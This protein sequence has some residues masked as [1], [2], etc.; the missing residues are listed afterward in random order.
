V[1]A[2]LVHAHGL[3]PNAHG[4][5]PKTATTAGVVVSTAIGIIFIIIL[6]RAFVIR[7]I[8]LPFVVFT[9]IFINIIPKARIVSELGVLA[10]RAIVLNTWVFRICFLGIIILIITVVAWRCRRRRRRRCRRRVYAAHLVVTQDQRF[11]ACTVYTHV[12]TVTQDLR[13]GAYGV[14]AFTII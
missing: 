11:D 12:G 1:G 3:G 6:V 14:D 13:A 8:P 7:S 4:L 10:V 9:R 2:L 5:G